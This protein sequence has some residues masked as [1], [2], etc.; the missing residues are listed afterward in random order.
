MKHVAQTA[1]LLLTLI[2][3]A[4]C[5]KPTPLVDDKPTAASG[6]NASASATS[7]TDPTGS[8]SANTNTTGSSSAT[9]ANT[10]E[11]KVSPYGLT[12]TVTMAQYMSER[13]SSFNQFDDAMRNNKQLVQSL[14]LYVANTTDEYVRDDAFMR[15]M[16]N[17]LC[18]IRI[19]LENTTSKTTK[20]DYISFSFDSGRELISFPF[21]TTAYAFFDDDAVFAV[22]NPKAVQDLIDD[23]NKLPANKTEQAGTEVPFEDG[24]YLWDADANGQVERLHA[25]FN[26]NGDEAPSTITL[27]LTGDGIDAAAYLN[28]AYSIE[29]IAEKADDKGPYLVVDYMQGDFYSHDHLAQCTLRYADGELQ[30]TPVES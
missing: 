24:S 14:Q 3:L 8:S 18:S 25:T 26:D 21:R 30:I 1:L 9:S 17:D 10:A 2:L 16:W 28:G 23:F 12:G 15:R 5:I 27:S 13:Y 6:A 11:Q 22:E 20:D 19:N 4:G 29:K 7:P